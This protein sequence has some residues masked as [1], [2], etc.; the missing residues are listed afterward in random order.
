MPLPQASPQVVVVT[1]DQADLDFFKNQ[2][3]VWPWPRQLYAHIIDYCRQSGARAVIFD[4]V[5]F[6]PSSYGPEDDARLA[7]SAAAAGNVAMAFFLSR[8][9]KAPNPSEADL[10]HKAGLNLPAPG[11]RACPTTVP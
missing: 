6:E 1:V 4:I 5:F 2:G 3:V 8:E 11:P 7:Q 9:D 10:L